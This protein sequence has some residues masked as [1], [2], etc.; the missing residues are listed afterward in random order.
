MLIVDSGRLGVI[1]PISIDDVL[2]L[3][4]PCEESERDTKVELSIFVG[5][6]CKFFYCLPLG[7]TASNQHLRRCLPLRLPDEHRFFCGT[8]PVV[9]VATLLADRWH[10]RFIISSRLSSADRMRKG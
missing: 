1:R 6:S 9:V 7:P 10:T 8:R 3:V 5:L 2:V 4:G